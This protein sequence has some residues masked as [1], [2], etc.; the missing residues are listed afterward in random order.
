VLLKVRTG[1]YAAHGHD[2]SAATT[3]AGVSWEGFEHAGW[4]AGAYDAV[5]VGDLER[6]VGE[7]LGLPASS[8]QGRNRKPRKIKGFPRQ[9]GSGS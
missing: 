2:G 1:A 6:G 3:G 5:G 7:E 8:M 4:V 9:V